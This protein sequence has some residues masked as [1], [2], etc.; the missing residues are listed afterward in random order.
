MKRREFIRL[1]GCLVI[2]GSAEARAQQ[3]GIPTIGFLS[4]GWERDYQPIIEAFRSGLAAF[5][6]A[7]GKNIRVLYRFANG[8]TGDLSTLTVDLASLGA[9]MIVTHNTATIQAAHNAAPHLPIVSWAAADPVM[10]GWAQTLARPGGMITGLFIVTPDSSVKRLELLKEVRPQATSFGYLFNS[11]N[12]GNPLFTRVAR[13]AARALGIKLEIIEVKNQSEITDALD[14]MR[15]LGVEGLAIAPDP[16]LG[17]NNAVIA[18][19]C[20]EHRLP[21][22]GDGRAFVDAGGLF[23]YEWDYATMA[24]RSAWYVD[25]ILQGIHPGNLPAEMAR[26]FKLMVNLKIAKELDITIPPSVLALAAE[27][28]E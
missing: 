20:R 22:V 21:S 4:L 13:D 8:N 5:G 11:T 23:A 24:K 16:V 26:E 6:Y 14:R 27:V 18:N 19:L 17:A 25:Q 7:E 10:M 12:P 9:V 15:S 2:A 3:P 28:I 1:V